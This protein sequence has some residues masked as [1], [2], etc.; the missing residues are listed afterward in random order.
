M[1]IYHY[2]DVK[3]A[4]LAF[5]ESSSVPQIMAKTSAKVRSKRPGGAITPGQYLEFKSKGCGELVASMRGVRG[6]TLT[7]AL[8]LPPAALPPQRQGADG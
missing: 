7:L 2:A 3:E 4:N 8:A 1:G 5:C 6:Q